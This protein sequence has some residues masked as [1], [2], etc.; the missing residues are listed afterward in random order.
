MAPF[1]SVTDLYMFIQ[2]S[3]IIVKPSSKSRYESRQ[4][5]N[6]AKPVC[7][8]LS[9]ESFFSLKNVFA[10]YKENSKSLAEN[11]QVRGVFARFTEC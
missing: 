11:L 1:S 4:L 3:P 2:V 8:L 10:S 6:L 7:I 9:T 5:I